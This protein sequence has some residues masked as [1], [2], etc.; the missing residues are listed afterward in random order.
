MGRRRSGGSQSLKSAERTRGVGGTGASLVENRPAL[1][2]HHPMEAAGAGGAVHAPEAEDA[3]GPEVVEEGPVAGVGEEEPTCQE[4]G[5]RPSTKRPLLA[6]GEVEVII[7]SAA[8]GE[9]RPSIEVGGIVDEGGHVLGEEPPLAGGGT[10]LRGCSSP[11]INDE[12]EGAALWSDVSSGYEW[13][14]G[15]ESEFDSEQEP[16]SERCG[17]VGAAASTTTTDSASTRAIPSTE[18]E[19]EAGADLVRG[20][21]ASLEARAPASVAVRGGG[22]EPEAQEAAAAAMGSTAADSTGGE[23][24]LL[25]APAATPSGGGEQ[26]AAGVAAAVAAATEEGNAAAHTVAATVTAAALAVAVAAAD[27]ENG[28]GAIRNGFGIKVWRDSSKYMGDWVAGKMTGYGEMRWADGR[29]YAGEWLDNRCNGKGVLTYKDGRQYIGEYKSDKMHGKGVYE[30]SE[31]AR[32][33]GNYR[34]HRKHG[35]GIMTWKTG[36]RYDGEYVDDKMTGQ[37]MMTWADGRRYEGSWLEGRCTGYGTTTFK[38][39]SRYVGNYVA[40]KMQGRG[41]YSFADGR[42]YEGEYQANQKHGRGVYRWPSGLLFTGAWCRGA[43]AAGF[44][45]FPGGECAKTSCTSSSSSDA[46]PDLALLRL[47]EEAQGWHAAREARARRV[48]SR[49]GGE[50]HAGANTDGQARL[51]VAS[52]GGGGRRRSE[53][54][55][56]WGGLAGRFGQRGADDSRPV[57]EDVCGDVCGSSA[58]SSGRDRRDTR[59]ESV[60][61]ADHGDGPAAVEGSRRRGGGRER[62]GAWG[63]GHGA[64]WHLMNGLRMRRNLGSRRSTRG[65]KARE[66]DASA[67]GADFEGQRHGHSREYSKDIETGNE[68]MRGSA[69]GDL[70]GSADMGAIVAGYSDEELD[71]W[72][73]DDSEDDEQPGRDADAGSGVAP[74]SHVHKDAI[75]ENAGPNFAGAER[76]ST[77]SKAGEIP[78]GKVARPELCEGDLWFYLVGEPPENAADW[79]GASGSARLVLNGVNGAGF[80]VKDEDG[81]SRLLRACERGLIDVVMWYIRAAWAGVNHCDDDGRTPLHAA[82]QFGQ[83][84]VVKFLLAAGAQTSSLDA[85]KRTPMYLACAAGFANAAFLACRASTEASML[86]QVDPLCH[87]VL[88]ASSAVDKSSYPRADLRAAGEADSCRSD[89]DSRWSCSG[90]D[91]SPAGAPSRQHVMAASNVGEPASREAPAAVPRRGVPESDPDPPFSRQRQTG[92]RGAFFAGMPAGGST[93]AKWQSAERSPATSVRAV[94]RV[95]KTWASSEAL[96]SAVAS[97]PALLSSLVRVSLCKSFGTSAQRA[98]HSL[99]NAIATHEHSGGKGAG[100][101]QLAVLEAL[102]YEPVVAYRQPHT[103]ISPAAG[104]EPA[105]GS[106]VA[107]VEVEVAQLACADGDSQACQSEKHPFSDNGDRILAPAVASRGDVAS[108]GDSSDCQVPSE[109]V[110]SGGEGEGSEGGDDREL[111]DLPPSLQ[112]CVQAIVASTLSL[113][114][115][116]DP[117]LTHVRGIFCVERHSAALSAIC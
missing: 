104:G 11:E 53:K 66:E 89:G 102:L 92:S 47:Q 22:A 41:C 74:A 46:C 25:D 90:R 80:N 32:Y 14:G 108:G 99:I 83:L 40:D 55:D 13:N 117:S 44:L 7:A 24:Q 116:D 113:H 57:V 60:R 19:D 17:S 10:L 28:D 91:A 56:R 15:S 114:L 16:V 69:R 109:G 6:S 70:V 86:A 8:V 64:K 88:S 73:K 20:C 101:H 36:G 111:R 72:D 38:S 49:A 39:G 26:G 42:R 48:E 4:D 54:K 33:V 30:W 97:R 98:A 79:P 52:A 37:G 94:L 112:Q 87:L 51:K 31:G 68:R 2:T 100:A 62:D 103:S 77:L 27:T 115:A 82:C 95:W 21:D 76:R 106:A 96:V 35:R 67:G 9:A 3:F 1:C 5:Q 105:G 45:L 29:R 85:Q 12:E 59:S 63:G 81:C 23:M 34:E 84:H 93:N 71:E 50:A 61:N 43:P 107:E 110:G 75:C 78:G 65:R 18:Y 58:H